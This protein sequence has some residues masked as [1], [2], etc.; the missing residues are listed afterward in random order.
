MRNSFTV[1]L[2]SNVFIAVH[3]D[4]DEECFCCTDYYEHN[5]IIMIFMMS[6]A[7]LHENNCI[8]HF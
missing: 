5:S 4:E 6:N 8:L 1:T 3:D 2:P 7:T